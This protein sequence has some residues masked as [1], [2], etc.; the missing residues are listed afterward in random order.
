MTY[1]P[2]RHHRRSIR[3]PTYDYTQP[4]AYFVTIC[5]QNRECVLGEVI[6]GQM[7]LNARGQMVES[8]WRQLP[9]HYPRV[10]VDAFVV[11]PNHVHG[12]VILVGAGP[13][14]C[15]ERPARPRVDSGQ[16]QGI[17]PTISLPDVVHRFK[18][19]TTAK[20]RTGVLQDGWQP[21]PGR[22]WQRNYYERVVRNDNDLARIRQYIVDNPARWQEDPENPV[23]WPRPQSL[24]SQPEGWTSRRNSGKLFG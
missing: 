18:S 1:D 24:V 10:E 14:A 5:T 9:Q 16:S 20:Y 19:L 22:L 21:F 3:L 15:P 6:Q 4:G 13:R 17:A 8:V 11:M 23:L 7:V 12:I 2:T